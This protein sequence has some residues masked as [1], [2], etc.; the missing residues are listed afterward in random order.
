VVDPIH[1]VLLEDRRSSALS[2]RAESRSLPKGFSMIT[3][4]WCGLPR[5]AR[6]G[7][8][9]RFWMMGS[10]TDGGVEM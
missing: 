8:S 9:P 10:K 1:L 3:F 5:Y 4:E 2:R 7:R 6:R